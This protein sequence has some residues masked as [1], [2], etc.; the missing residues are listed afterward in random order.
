MRLITVVLC[1]ALAPHVLHAQPPKP[2]SGEFQLAGIEATGIKRLSREDV[3]TLASVEVGKP[4]RVDHLQAVAEKLAA[5]GV[6]TSVEYAYRTAA[7][8]LTLTL[9]LA[10]AD[11]NVPVVFDNFVWMTDQQLTAAVGEAFPSFEGTV[12]QN[13]H[14]PDRIVRVLQG[15][16]K[17]KGLPGTVAFM[18]QTELKTNALQFLFKV[19]D[20]APVTCNVSLSGVSADPQTEMQTAIKGLV[21]QPYSRF[22]VTNLVNATLIDT[23]RRLGF[24]AASFSPPAAS[25]EGGCAGVT[26]LLA[27]NEGVPYAWQGAEWRGNT[28]LQ[29]AALDT[30]LAMKSGQLADLSRI[31]AGLRQVSRAYGRIGHIQASTRLSP[32]LDHDA[33]RAV[34]EIEV[35]EGAQFKMGSLEVVGFSEPDAAAITKR[36][37]LAPGQ[38]YNTA[39]QDDFL[40]KELSSYRRPGLKSP[41]LQLR[42]NPETSVVD[43]RIVQER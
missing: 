17:A 28:A 11:W 19:V 7:G 37:A 40:S 23:Y 29:A 21:G 22:Y 10:E 9:N 20:P 25:L 6:F 33:R 41:G 2:P 8:R 14:V 1:L 26:V 32:R 13:E 35:N 12:P 3:A 5:S 43:V 42:V 15:Q 31:N 4:I 38:V 36:W 16:L 39:Y 27:A 24:W 30:L 18:P 34:F